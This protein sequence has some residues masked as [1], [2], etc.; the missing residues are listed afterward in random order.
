MGR[1]RNQA[2]YIVWGSNGTLPFKRGIPP[3]PGVYAHANVPTNKRSHQTE[4]PVALMRE[5]LEIVPVGSTVL[6]PFMGSG[7]TGVACVETGRDF[8]G[9]ELNAEYFKTAQQRI[10]AALEK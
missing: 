4:K 7:S 8:V 5:L 2:E 10:G 3:L 6:D 1:F 9:I